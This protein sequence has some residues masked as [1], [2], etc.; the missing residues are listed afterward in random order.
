[1]LTFILVLIKIKETNINKKKCFIIYWNL[2]LTLVA[3]Y[4]FKLKV[5]VKAVINNWTGQIYVD[6]YFSSD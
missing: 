3:H 1:M 4:F 2:Q 6:F 5:V